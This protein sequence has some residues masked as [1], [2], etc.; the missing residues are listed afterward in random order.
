MNLLTTLFGGAL[1]IVA[2]YFVLGMLRLPNFWRAVVS[3]G[4]VLLIYLVIVARLWPG[5]DVVAMHIAVFIVTAAILS[6]LHRRRAEQ[7]PKL[8]WAP[9]VLIGF[10]LVLFVIDGAFIYIASH[11]LPEFIAKRV[12]PNADK[13]GAR[14]AFPGVMPHGEDAAKAVNSHLKQQAEKRRQP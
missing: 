4:A 13:G 10:F 9:K 14:T 12:M 6:L 5:L 7:A 11:G 1:L 3:G 2:L 8:H